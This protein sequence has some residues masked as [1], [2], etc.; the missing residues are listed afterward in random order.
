[1]PSINRCEAFGLVLLEAM[2]SGLPCLAADLPGV[3]QVIEP[4][5]NGLLIKPNDASDLALQIKNILTDNQRRVAM[6]QASRQRAEQ[7][8]ALSNHNELLDIYI[9][10]I[11]NK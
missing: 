7:R 2:A 9:N 6:A 5:V 1:L 8:F 10:V 11:G 4:L 3:R